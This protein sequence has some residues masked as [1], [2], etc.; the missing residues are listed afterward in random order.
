MIKQVTASGL[1]ASTTQ[2]TVGLGV[3][4]WNDTVTDTVCPFAID[5]VAIY[6]RALSSFEISSNYNEILS[7][8]N[9]YYIDSVNGCDNNSGKSTSRPWKS[10]TKINTTYF[11]PGSRINI[12]SNTSYSG[13]I[14]PLSSGEEDN[15][16]TLTSYGGNEKPIINGNGVQPATIYLFNVEYW[17]ISNLKITNYHT[18]IYE[19]SG[20]LV[21]NQYA[22]VLNHFYII[23]NEIYNCN[24][25]VPGNW[26]GDRTNGGIIFN[27]TAPESIGTP[28]PSKMN[29]V[30]VENNYIHQTGRSGI[31]FYS[32]FCQRYT[33]NEGIGSWYGSTNVVVRN[34][35][36]YDIGGD[37]IVLAVVS[38][39]LIEHNTAT[40]CNNVSQ[41]YNIAIWCGNCDDTIIQYNEAS[42]TQLASG[43]AQGFDLDFASEGNILQYNY[44]HDNE[45]GFV[46]VCSHSSTVNIDPI[47]RYNISQNDMQQ[48]FRLVG[49]NTTGAKIYN[50]T[51]YISSELSTIPISTIGGEG[52]VGETLIANNIFYNEGSGYNNIHLTD[53]TAEMAYLFDQADGTDSGSAQ[54]NAIT[55]GAPT[56]SLKNSTEP[57]SS[58]KYI[59][60]TP[61]DYLKVSGSAF[62]FGSNAF[63]ILCW[64]KIPSNTP[65]NTTIRLFQNGVWGDH[66]PGFAAALTRTVNN[67]IFVGTGV[68]STGTAHSWSWES[69]YNA[70]QGQIIPDFFDSQWHHLA[71]IFDQPKGRYMMLL[72][73]YL[74]MYKTVSA[75][76]LNA[77]TTQ[78]T[79]GLG[80]FL[81]NDTVTDTVCPLTI[82][83]VRIYQCAVNETALLDYVIHNGISEVT[84]C[85]NCYYSTQTRI[86]EPI[87]SHKIISNPK[88]INPGTG[89]FGL[90]SL[91]GYKLASDSPCINAGLTVS[92]SC[93]KD[94]W[95][96]MILHN[97]SI[98]IGAH[99]Y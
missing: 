12:K 34:N 94:F 33:I 58:C 96:N 52:A 79:V 18:S 45:G 14:K 91:S 97:S 89:T 39:G 32:V 50:N 21:E 23:N 86:N 4:L 20:I 51:I 88:L 84:Y 5:D 29:D 75:T 64:V 47:V 42:Y 61:T 25:D 49:T 78:S 99:E 6:N 27:I 17:E 73:G 24:G 77:S 37:G 69:H 56:Y 92:G 11:S 85:H 74:V 40:L 26:G 90:Q 10:I 16:I 95:G 2:S 57:E 22:G 19:R 87:D 8:S 41:N 48:V 28:V 80:V 82:D 44:S 9:I 70:A 71:F 66:S 53:C 46:L 60:I 36:L 72:D 13:Q 35:I 1:T 81:W 15:A 68:G 67:G 30:R 3:F 62:Q 7:E 63:S 76:S 65:Y 93:G 55:V 31:F 98:D 59:S 83:D 38:G 43:D 54:N